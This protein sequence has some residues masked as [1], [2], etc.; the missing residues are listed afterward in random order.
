L[1]PS[2]FND[3]ELCEYIASNDW[4]IG[5][6]EEAAVANFNVNVFK[7]LPGETEE[8]HEKRSD[9]RF[10]GTLELVNMKTCHPIQRYDS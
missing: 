9:C 5:M 10:L 4:V 2:L 8:T 3:T 6:W 1:I 7:N